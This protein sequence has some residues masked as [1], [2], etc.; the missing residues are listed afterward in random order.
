MSVAQGKLFPDHCLAMN[1]D[2][3]AIP[4]DGIP[5]KDPTFGLSALWIPERDTNK[6]RALGYTVVDLSTVVATHFKE[7]IRQ[8][9]HELLSRQDVQ[10]MLDSLAESNPKVVEEVVPG[11]LPLGTVQKVLQNLLKEQVP[12]RDLVTIVETLGDYGRSV[13]DPDLLT[14]YV[15]GRLARTISSLYQDTD[16]TL[17]AFVLDQKIEEMIARSVQHTDQGS[18]LT[19]N[20]SAAQ[21]I[22]MQINNS[23]QKGGEGDHY[24]VL[25]CSG[26]VRRYIRGLTERFIPKLVTLAYHEIADNIKIQSLGIVELPH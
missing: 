2:D 15:R 11:L 19:L 5:T 21:D 8:H 17:F 16:G 3:N 14:E 7:V 9:S 22:I 18:H 4:I 25:L 26:A 20:P 1:S 10:S 24:P 6:A 13:K 12:V 23:I